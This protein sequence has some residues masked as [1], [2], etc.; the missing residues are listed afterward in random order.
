[1]T[2]PFERLATALAD[3]YRIERE[4]GAGG[5]ATV[6]LAHDVRHDRKVAL[7]VL[8]PE[9]AAVIGAERFL[10]EIKT[11]ANLQH[12]HILAL[13]DSGQVDGTVF[14]VMPFVDGESLR[15]R[16]GRE[17]QLPI[18]DALRIARE[19]GDAMHYAHAHGVIHRDIKPE[20]IL[21]Q[22]G[23]A[24][25][26]D[27]GIALAASKTGGA[28]MTETGM[29][30]GTPTYMS[31][32]Q[33]MGERTLDARTDIYAL[34]CVLYE[35]L[36]GDAP[37]TGSTAQAI[38]AKVLTEKPALILPRRDRVPQHVEDAIL[39]ALE[40]L[41][42]DR[43]ATAAEFVA[44]LG[45]D[46]AIM[47]SAAMRART[48]GRRAVRSRWSAPRVT[49]VALL[50]AAIAGSLGWWVGT[51][52]ASR[53]APPS[54]LAIVEP[55]TMIHFF[56]IARTV[57]I[58]SD[59]QTI[60]FSAADVGRGTRLLARRLD[61][62]ESVE[63]PNTTNPAHVKLSPDARFVYSSQDRSTMQRMPLAGGAWV[64]LPEVEATSFI[65]FG[66][67]GALWWAS[68]L[69]TGTHRLGADGRDSLWSDRYNINQILPGG[70]FALAV[71]YG[72][73]SNSGIAQHIDLRSREAKPIFDTPV[74]EVRYTR[75]Y[76][77]YVRP[78]NALVAAPF[79]ARTGRVTGE[80]VELATDVT[81]SG[82]GFAQWA[83]A[84]NGTVIYVPG[85][86][87]EL[88]RVARDGSLRTLVTEQQRYH[89]PRISPDGR[90]VAVD[91][92]R[93]DGRDVWLHTAGGSEL[94]RA[95]FSRDGHDP[96]WTLDGRG[97]YYLAGD[98][99]RLAVFR[100]QPGT[101]TQ[102]RPEQIPVE[103]GYTGTPLAGGRGMLSLVP[104]RGGR[105]SD[106]VRVT[107]GSAAVDTL[108]GTTAD[109]A[110]AVPSPD[111]RWFAYTSDHSGRGEIYLRSLGGSDVL[112][113]VSLDGGAEPVWSRDG[114]ELF[115]RRPT[116]SGAELTAAAIQYGT[117]PRVVSRT[118]LFDA[119]EFDTSTPHANYDVAPDGRSFVFVRRSGGTHIVVLQ[120]VP[121][122]ARRMAAGAGVPR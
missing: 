105:G 54:R 24:Q 30:L 33:A 14:Y 74:I 112:L 118:R 107:P 40:K 66:A 110:Y 87:N 23:H 83:V 47:E 75:G 2:L 101:T 59:G 39:T 49:A 88:V 44:A 41:P 93:S 34:G 106:I 82:S 98:G 70:R 11:T 111:G 18:D 46:G 119:S 69:G 51:R 113:Q 27:F 114:R 37:F 109:E 15:D 28:R 52:G 61:R 22:G 56:G 90:T 8:K 100:A 99:G 85:F 108:V 53:V 42:A 79:N 96:V 121:E 120:N 10:A 94:T 32:E 17:K 36:T 72:T 9:L 1:M 6:Y 102:P 48:T 13:F 78:D 29:S 91:I 97:F 35:M 86:A 68:P 92:V 80:S 5:M 7:K 122:M 50:A 67:D 16:I 3:R 21:L 43:F 77:L 103:V 26:A 76:L 19:V 45:S 55:G 38:V 25:V 116:A 89:S 63:V 58:S 12:P 84:D 71:E 4:L 57:D 81:L 64:A 117:E 60:V 31:P 73:A 65:T 104:G 95:T 62:K 115:Y 20:N